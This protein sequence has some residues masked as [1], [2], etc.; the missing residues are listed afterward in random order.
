[1][2]FAF[3]GRLEVFVEFMLVLFEIEFRP[4]LPASQLLSGFLIEASELG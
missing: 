3:A 4:A 2:L 1:L